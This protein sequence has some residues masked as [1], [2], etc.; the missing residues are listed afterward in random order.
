MTKIKSAAH[1]VCSVFESPNPN[2]SVI[3]IEGEGHD[4]T[5]LAPMFNATIKFGS[6]HQ[7]SENSSTAYSGSSYA[8]YGTTQEK[9]ASIGKW[10]YGLALSKETAVSQMV[11]AAG[12]NTNS[13]WLPMHKMNMDPNRAKGSIQ[14]FTKSTGE[15]R[16]FW[17]KNNYPYSRYFVTG[18]YNTQ[19]NVELYQD[20]PDVSYQGYGGQGGG[21]SEIDAPILPVWNNDDYVVWISHQCKLYQSY[22]DRPLHGW[23][24]ST[25]NGHESV[26]YNQ[27]QRDHYV[28]QF[29]GEG[30]D[31]NPVFMQNAKDN[32]YTQYIMRYNVG[33]NNATQLHLFN[34]APSAAGTSYGG[35]RGS[36]TI[37]SGICKWASETFAD[38]T[39]GA[40]AADKGFYQPYFDTNY[41]YHPH[42]YQ[43]DVSANTFTRNVD[44]TISGDKSSTH[45]A[46][47]YNDVGNNAG[48]RTNCWNDTHVHGGT[49]YLTV[50]FISGDPTLADGGADSHRSFVT[51]SCGA[52]DPKTL[53]HHS[54]A[55]VPET[56]TNHVWLNDAKSIMGIITHQAIYVYTWDNTNGWERTDTIA[57]KFPVVG[58]DSTDRIWALEQGTSGWYADIHVLSLDV[59]TKVTVTPAASSYNYTG[60]TINTSV[61]VSAYNISSE[62]IATTVKLTID[63]TSMQFDSDGNG[64]TGTD[65]ATITTLTNADITKNV[66]IVSA[67]LSDIIANI[68]L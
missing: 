27:T 35:A 54:V 66:N 22:G 31:G 67:G 49:R 14:R 56:I 42:Y 57:G 37:G 58:R 45:M 34:A 23:G 68:T 1:R 43:W 41:D 6:G 5:T 17:V 40:D 8:D 64:N 62:R 36:V 47:P 26:D 20:A 44:I 53:T 3:Y 7:G 50:M 15:D 30:T 18:W 29:I 46:F 21:N 16:I 33:A 19:N 32:D 65:S 4:K 55:T 9:E 13:S 28:T 63:G 52:S 24:R 38:F 10:G 39:S 61:G 25:F 51:Y 60:S 12:N 2:H 48:L 59:P 11:P